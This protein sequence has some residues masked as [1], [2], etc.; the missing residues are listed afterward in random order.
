MSTRI[1]QALLIG[2]VGVLLLALGLLIPD[3]TNINRGE[4]RESV[5]FATVAEQSPRPPIMNEPSVSADFDVATFNDKHGS[6]RAAIE[7]REASTEAPM[8][9]PMEEPVE[10]LPPVKLAMGEPQLNVTVAPELDLQECT[11]ILPQHVEFTM[12]RLHSAVTSKNPYEHIVVHDIF[13]PHVYSCILAHLPKPGANYG[14]TLS[15]G[16]RNYFPLSEGN[17]KL[18]I[19]KNFMDSQKAMLAPTFQTFWTEFTRHFAGIKIRDAW[20]N[21]FRATLSKRFPNL[22]KSIVAEKFFY[23]LDMS[24]DGKNYFIS[25]HTDAVAKVIT[26]LYYLPTN[27]E[28]PELGTIAYK[29]KHGVKDDGRGMTWKLEQGDPEDE[30]IPV[31]EGKFIPNTVFAFAPCKSSWHGVSLVTSDLQRDTPQGFVS[32]PMTKKEKSKKIDFSKSTVG[33]KIKSA[34]ISA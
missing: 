18:L 4:G 15:K 24:R 20:I 19:P 14:G 21:L 22:K 1:A 13:H 26:I 34:C 31:V 23:R 9:Q 28:H 27:S 7:R 30:F 16:L 29:S 2:V 6:V 32:M 33:S 17:G 5:S 8:E 25:P 11:H 10:E 12:H 3:S